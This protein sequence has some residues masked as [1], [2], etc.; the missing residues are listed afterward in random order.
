MEKLPSEIYYDMLRE[1]LKRSYAIATNA[2]KQG[3]DPTD[4]VE[5]KIAKDVAARVEGIVGPPGVEEVIR[6][7]EKN[8]MNREDIAFEVARKIAGGELIKGNKEIL[9]EQAVRSALGIITEGVL[10][11]PTEGIAKVKI[12]QN[13]DGSDYV[14]VYYAGP[15]RS[16]GGTAAAMS[17]MFADVARRVCGV[18]DYRATE[19]QTMRYLEEVGLYESRVAHLQYMPPEEHMKIITSSCPVCID[20]EPSEEI[21]V[22]TYRGVSGVETDRVRGGVPLVLCEGVAAKA[23]KLNKYSKKLKLGWDFLEKV[24]KVKTKQDKIEVKADNTYLEGLVAG[25]PVFSHPSIAGGFRLRYGRS[26]TNSLMGKNIHPA[27]MILLDNFLAFGTQMKIER[28]GKGCVV[29][30]H[31][32]IE[33]PVVKLK[34]G[35]VTKVRTVEEAHALK[36][37]VASVL[38]LGDMLSTYGD[39][40]KSNHP[41]IPSGYCVEWWEAEIE[42]KNLTPPQ[43]KDAKSLFEFSKTHNVPVHPDYTYPWHDLDAK[44]I[45]DLAEWLAQAVIESDGKK[46]TQMKLPLPGAKAALEDLL[47]EHH[48]VDNH[49]IISSDDAYSLLSSIGA[50]FQFS[51]NSKIDISAFLNHWSDQIKPLDLVNKFAHIK[52]KAPTYIGARMGRPEKAKERKMDGS[53]HVLFPTGSFKNRSVTKHYRLLRSQENEHTLLLEIARYRCHKCN[54]ICFTRRCDVCSGQAHAEL[55]CQK[56]GRSVTTE[57]HCDFKTLSYDKRPVD[58][59]ALYE[60]V[61]SKLGF[62]PDEVKGIKGLSN[63]TKVAERL[64]KG[65]L[66]AK[67]DV[68]VFRDGTCRFDA[69]DVPLTHFVPRQVGLSLKKAKELGYTKDYRGNPIMSDEQ[70]IP[71]KHQDI[72][73]AENGVQYLLKVANFIDDMLINLYGL[74]P[75]YSIKN[76]ED[77]I[78]HLCVGLSPHTSA[79]ALCRIIGFTRANVGYG[80]PYFHTAKRRNCDADEDCIMLLM[81]ALINFSRKF[82]SEMRGGTMDAPLVLSLEINPKE[83]DDESHSI[84]YVT[85]YPLEFYL[86][87]EKI[88]APSDVKLRTVKDVLGTEEQYELPLTHPGGSIDSGNI[89]TAYVELESIP[90]KINIQFSLQEKIKAVDSKDAAERLILSHFIPD[91]YG[92]LRSFSRQTFRC[93]SC[94]TIARR[95]PLSGKCGRCGGN[96]LLTINKG[97][98][99]KYLSISSDIVKRYGLPLY[100]KQ[101]LELLEKEIKSIFDDDKIK[102]LGLSDFL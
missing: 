60:A 59:V 24:I 35:R 40:L 43:T 27:T 55:V 98:I 3:F 83:V 94:N 14:A 97:G 75:F 91:L 34:N 66:R 28:P 2:R 29:A 39:F 95:P 71:L 85:K 53:P 77:L 72:V 96:L 46:I 73:L 42:S 89:R 11:A 30:S 87:A 78:G 25:R 23:A 99:Q 19:T 36:R 17:L 93:V 33:P 68:Y 57:M 31:N 82:L 21:E 45:K 5:V 100:L 4:E 51:N 70:I 63:P 49:A 92:N 67:H 16:A 12:K 32:N 41:L 84:E 1:E 38:F 61:G 9:I 58:V 44:K 86:A 79:G 65:F 7:L 74:R 69:T 48:I 37:D 50:D 6:A 80:H 102:Q 101:R 15:I 64:E 62:T 54:R 20:G 18:G 22:S 88:T 76:R 81:D 13:P 52:A 26:E 47:I 10:V 90:D 8:G 56:C